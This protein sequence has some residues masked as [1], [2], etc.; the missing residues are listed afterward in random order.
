[1]SK[2]SA[3]TGTRVSSLEFDNPFP[4]FAGVVGLDD[5]PE[6][7]GG[8]GV[9]MGRS[10]AEEF[11]GLQVPAVEIFARLQEAFQ[12]IRI[13]GDDAFFCPLCFVRFP[14]MRQLLLET[15]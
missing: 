14:E 1:M 6:F 15:F 9:Q 2:G 7:L 12:N 11:L 10:L 3:L 8:L 13:A 5:A 4:P